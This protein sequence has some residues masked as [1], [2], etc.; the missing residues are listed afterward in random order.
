MPRT[1]FYNGGERFLAPLL[2]KMRERF[3]VSQGR[4]H[5]AGASNGGRSAFRVA[6]EYPFEF[7]SI[8]VLPGYA[9]D[10][11]LPRLKRLENMRVHMFV[12][13][14]DTNWVEESRKTETALKALG[15]PTTLE[16]LDGDGHVPESLDGDVIMKHLAA[17][18]QKSA[19]PAG[20][21]GDVHRAIDDFNDAAAKADED[22]YFGSFAPE[23][24]FLGTDPKERWNLEEFK[25][26]GWPYFTK[27]SSA[28][29]FVPQQRW[30]SVT[31]DGNSASFHERLGSRSYGRCRGTGA[32]R[33][34]NGQ[35]KVTLYDLT[36]PIPNDLMK[37]FVGKIV[38]E[39]A[40][41][42]LTPC[43]LEL[44][45]KSPCMRPP[46]NGHYVPDEFA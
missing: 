44:G 27:R 24:V 35:W 43:I 7:Q 34:I 20:D 13:G 33:K 19:W 18:H 14:D 42:H 4:M 21:V 29:I 5:L 28:W 10:A 25:A 46:M 39:A 40:A 9:L 11:D 38:L 23:G 22:R 36:V 16:V 26:F 30:V 45:G 1:A 12:G 3:R 2:I 41:K 32:L 31:P 37:G 6:T 8:T 17:A 15:I